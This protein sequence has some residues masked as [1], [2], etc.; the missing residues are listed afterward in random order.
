[1]IM[2]ILRFPSEDIKTQ[3]IEYSKAAERH[4]LGGLVASR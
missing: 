2:L 1:M 4:R 3:E